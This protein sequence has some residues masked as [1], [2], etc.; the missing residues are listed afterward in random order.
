M[1]ESDLV[2]TSKL[3]KKLKTFVCGNLHLLLL[4]GAFK[5]FRSNFTWISTTGS[6]ALLDHGTCLGWI[7]PLRHFLNG[8]GFVNRS[9]C[10]N[11]RFF[12]NTF[13]EALFTKTE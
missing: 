10:H 5:E 8:G 2:S 7:R 13:G 11:A 4:V 1:N 12:Q 6:N 9:I 3:S